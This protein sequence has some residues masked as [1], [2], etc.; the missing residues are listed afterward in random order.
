MPPPSEEATPLDPSAAR[1][2]LVADDEPMIR[3]A[4][5]FILEKRGHRVTTAPDA[6]TA[7]ELVKSQSFGAVLVDAGMPGDGLTVL[8]HLDGIDYPGVRVLMTGGL[9]ADPIALS[10]GVHLLQKPFPFAAV[11]PLV[12]EDAS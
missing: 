5:R 10:P 11:I 1:H 2:V 6:H 8:S 7:L 4:L 9:G 12:E 3:K